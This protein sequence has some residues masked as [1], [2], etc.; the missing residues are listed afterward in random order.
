M[1]NGSWH[2]KEQTELDA[3]MDP[4]N[5]PPIDEE[6]MQG[7]LKNPPM[8]CEDKETSCISYMENGE[9]CRCIRSIFKH[10]KHYEH[11]KNKVKDE[12]EHAFIDLISE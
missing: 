7:L 4:N 10:N 2:D 8:Y 12:L 6:Q 9:R 3:F 11:Y 5:V 1:K